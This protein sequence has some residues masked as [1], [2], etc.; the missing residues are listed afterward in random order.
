VRPGRA[1][2]RPR[3]SQPQPGPFRWADPALNRQCH[4]LPAGRGVLAGL[5]QRAGHAP[6]GA[7]GAAPAPR[8]RAPRR[9]TGPAPMMNW[10]RR[11]RAPRLAPSAQ[12]FGVQG[13]SGRRHPS[14]PRAP[15][16]SRRR[17]TG[18]AQ[19]D[20]L[21]QRQESAVKL[22]IWHPAHRRRAKWRRTETKNI[23]PA[24]RPRSPA[25]GRESAGPADEEE[26]R[27]ERVCGIWCGHRCC[28]LLLCP[29]LDLPLRISNYV[30]GLVEL[31]GLEPPTP[32]VQ[33]TGSASTGVRPCRSASWGV[34]SHPSPSRP[35]AVLPRCT[36]RCTGADLFE[37]PSASLFARTQARI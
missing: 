31:G 32:C 3:A 4:Q 7:P 5:G 2:G 30:S 23:L 35:V 22:Q 10:L 8:R 18:P 27:F 26:A 29:P 19:T 14:G 15:A 34:H 13:G 28:T 33:T 24:Q 12:G 6:T 1:Y 11:E 20:R 16:R 17:R 36:Q 25:Q 21:H 9:T 37:C